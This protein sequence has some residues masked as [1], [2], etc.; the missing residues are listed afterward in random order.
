MVVSL[1]SQ[2]PLLVTE[3]G[4]KASVLWT[5]RRS[6]LNVP[7]G[8]V[9]TWPALRGVFSAVEPMLPSDTDPAEEELEAAVEI[10]RSTDLTETEMGRGVLEELSRLGVGEDDNLIARSSSSSED[11][12]ELAFPGVFLSKRVKGDPV[13]VLEGIREVYASR[14]SDNAIAYVLAV[15]RRLGLRISL[16]QNMA[17]LVQCYLKGHLGGVVFTK[18]PLGSPYGRIEVTRGGSEPIVSGAQPEVSVLFRRDHGIVAADALER[19][20]DMCDSREVARDLSR[21]LDEA[22]VLTKSLCIGEQDI[23]WLWDGARVWI[24]QARPI[25]R[26]CQGRWLKR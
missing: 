2:M 19:L 20:A 6:A 26:R 22:V 9:I 24:V 23:E 15:R 12:S 10:V 17:V 14:F 16:I 8:F 7:A 21:Q 13:D 11:T 1:D 3:C 4:N 18:D 5:L 25:T